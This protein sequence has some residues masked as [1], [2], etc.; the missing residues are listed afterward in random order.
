M[1]QIDERIPWPQELSEVALETHSEPSKE[2]SIPSFVI[3]NVP[4]PSRRVHMAWS[5]VCTKIMPISMTSWSKAEPTSA[6]TFHFALESRSQSLRHIVTL[7]SSTD[8]D[9]LACGTESCTF[10]LEFLSLDLPADDFQGHSIY[11]HG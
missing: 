10:K 11:Q 5:T 7:F 9:K 2:T 4:K 6:Q 1:G 8:Q 3:G